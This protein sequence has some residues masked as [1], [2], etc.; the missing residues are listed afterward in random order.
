MELHISRDE[1][2]EQLRLL[3][4]LFLYII[5][6]KLL[7]PR[8]VLTKTDKLITSNLRILTSNCNMQTIDNSLLP[9]KKSTHRC[10]IT[11]DALKW[12]TVITKG[13][14]LHSFRV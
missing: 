8:K 14:P 12:D 2:Y 9:P 3:S 1:K 7:T 4:L 13:L 11:K 10:V 6:L 5:M